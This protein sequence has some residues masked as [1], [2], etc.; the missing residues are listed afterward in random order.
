M[1][2]ALKIIPSESLNTLVSRI[3]LIPP[4]SILKGYKFCVSVCLDVWRCMCVTVQ[5]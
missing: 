5:S 2:M 1:L 4:K 3:A